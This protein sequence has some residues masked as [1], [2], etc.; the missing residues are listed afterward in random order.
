MRRDILFVFIGRGVTV[1]TSFLAVKSATNIMTPHEY[2]LFAILIAFQSLCGLFFINPVGQYINRH[3]HEWIEDKLIIGKLK[4]YYFYTIVISIIGGGTA[5]FWFYLKGEVFL[6]LLF[7]FIVVLLTVFFATWNATF[8]TILNMT[9]Y[10]G[11]AVISSVM[12]AIGGLLFSVTLSFMFP[13]GLVWFFGQLLGMVF[14]VFIGIILLKREGFFKESKKSAE[15]FINLNLVRTYILPLSCATGLMW[16]LVSGYRIIIEAN[17]GLATL[18]SLA[19]GFGLA[20][21]MFSVLESLVVQI[22]YPIFYKRISYGDAKESALAFS[23]LL[24]VLAPI[25]FIYGAFLIATSS[26]I[27]DLFISDAF[28]NV[29][30]FFLFGILI[31]CFR[32]V[33]NLITSGAQIG[34]RM[35]ILIAPY[36]VPSIFLIGYLVVGVQRIN[37]LREIVWVVFLA[38]AMVFLLLA[39]HMRH[40][41]QFSFRIRDWFFSIVLLVSSLWFFYGTHYQPKYFFEKIFFLVGIIMLV[42]GSLWLILRRNDALYRMRNVLL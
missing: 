10:R 5:T 7:V 38:H 20:G 26:I 41:I 12:T 34:K 33:T 4:Y 6:N 15:K 35:G 39:T 2:G 9:G 25:Y 8:N 24:N 40:S 32:A 13:K 11:A 3:T 17:V 23:D 22:L 19:V 31:E 29:S 18:G 28:T 21:Q 27:L 42:G 36:L 1:A 37:F 30:V 14:G 16:W